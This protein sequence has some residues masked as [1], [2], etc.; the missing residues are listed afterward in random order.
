MTNRSTGKCPFSIVYTKMPNIVLDIAALPKSQS[1][2]ASTLADQF[3]SLLFD[4]RFK[5]EESN[6]Q[7]KL[8]ADAHRREKIFHPGELVYVR[9]RRE[10]LPP[11]N[12]SKLTKKKWGP[13]PIS[14]RINN[15]AYVVDLPAKFTTS[16][17]F[18]V[19]DIYSYVPP[20]DSS[21][22][23]ESVDTDSS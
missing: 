13:Y 23:I 21:I 10:W 16:H 2:A 15:N 17:T 22:N 7:Y 18:N 11:G 12:H 8:K 9:L 3:T 1:K 20:D 4:V 19:A 14:K 5:L 6:M